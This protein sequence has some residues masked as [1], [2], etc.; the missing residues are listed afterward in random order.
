MLSPINS[1]GVNL[2]ITGELH[3]PLPCPCPKLLPPMFIPPWKIA[4]PWPTTRPEKSCDTVG[5]G[6]CWEALSV[7]CC[8]FLSSFSLLTACSFSANL[9]DPS[10]ES[11]L[12]ITYFCAGRLNYSAFLIDEI[13]RILNLDSLC[14]VI[15]SKRA[16][17]LVSNL[18]VSSFSFLNLSVNSISKRLRDFNGHVMQL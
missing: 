10:T 9:A 18:R 4:L 1:Q 13:R 11:R 3:P 15:F 16:T 7:I 12:E 2:S 8:V 5:A 17:K 14:S 6:F